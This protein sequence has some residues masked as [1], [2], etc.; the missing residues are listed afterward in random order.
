MSLFV[1]FI[2]EQGTRQ[3]TKDSS[4]VFKILWGRVQKRGVN[5]AGVD[6]ER[7]RN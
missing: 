7:R 6:Y 4:I 1:N 5:S 3:D 2:A